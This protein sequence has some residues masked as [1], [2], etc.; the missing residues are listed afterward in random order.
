[1]TDKINNISSGAVKKATG[2]DWDG[3]IRFIDRRGGASMDHRAIV[4]LLA[5]PGAVQSGWWQQTVAVGYEHK[6]GKRRTGQTAGAGFQVGVQRAVPLARRALWDLLTSEA[7]LRVWLGSVR[8]LRFQPG[9]RFETHDQLC[10]QIRTVKPTE[11]VRLSWRPRRRKAATTLQLSLS[12]P[13][14]TRARTTLRFHHEKLRSGAERERMRAHWKAVLERLV[15][16]ARA[17]AEPG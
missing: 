9:E 12:C 7:G 6:K 5:G 17:R 10:G 1:M 2:R 13:R 11:R 4:A 3:W 14:N 15:E 8:G 16:L